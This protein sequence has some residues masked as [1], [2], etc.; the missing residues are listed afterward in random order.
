MMIIPPKIG[1]RNPA[2]AS[3]QALVSVF[4]EQTIM[5][6]GGEFYAQLMTAVQVAQPVETREVHR[7]LKLRM[8]HIPKN[9]LVAWEVSDQTIE[10]CKASRASIKD[11]SRPK[12]PMNFWPN[13]EL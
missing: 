11:H 5:S 3:C 9:G 1:M 8:L 6:P 2:P 12:Q 10:M 4:T 13:L 7:V